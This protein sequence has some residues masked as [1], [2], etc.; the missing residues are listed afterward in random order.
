MRCL[1]LA[2]TA[3]S[4]SFEDT[5]AK[6]R[7]VTRVITLLNDMQK[8]LEKEQETDEE[9]FEQMQ[10]WC[11]T[12]DKDKTAAIKEAEQTIEQLSARIEELTAQSARLHTEIGNLNEEVAENQEALAKATAIREKE[13]AAFTQEEKDMLEAIKSLKSAITVLSKHHESS[14][15]QES[16][17]IHLAADLHRQMSKFPDEFALN[18][19]PADR[20][21]L[22][23]FLQAPGYK[24]YNS[25][26]GQIFGILKNMEE[27]F[28]SNLSDTQKEEQGRQSLFEELKASKEDQIEAGQAQVNKKTEQ[29]A[30]ADNNNSEAKQQRD[31]TRNSL[32][33]DEQ[34]LMNLKEKCAM[35]DKEWEQRQKA[36]QE[37]I[38][39]VGKAISI[40]SADDSHDTFTKTFESSFV[41][42]SS[43]RAAAASVL[44][45]AAKKFHNPR[46]A[47]LASHV[48]LDAFT[49]VKAAIDQLMV[50]LQKQKEDEIKHK[51]W[52]IVALNENDRITGNR[53]R[54]KMDTQAIIESQK[55][56]IENLS[57]RIKLLYSEVAEIRVQ[58]K[59]AGEDREKQNAEFQETVKDQRESQGLLLKAINVLKAVY[60]KKSFLQEEPAGPPP[61][62]GFGAYKKNAQSGGVISMI[63]QIIE[64]AKAMEAEAIKD[65]SDAQKAYEEYVQESNQSVQTKMKARVNDEEAK[66]LTEQALVESGQELEGLNVELSQLSNEKQDVNKSCDFVLKNFDVRQRARDEEV[67]ALRQAKAI[68]SG[69]KFGFLQKAWT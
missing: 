13:Y 1:F 3:S 60:K 38:V 2:L 46:L 21:M 12:N 43:D 34:F 36:R 28:E 24:S 35:T 69:S 19:L 64:D 42:V 16:D 17:F 63:E 37:E 32:S 7:P 18:L 20:R 8:Q 25:Q 58:L 65:E 52:C 23:Q 29:K 9:V 56:K 45:Q 4:I 47:N 10:C 40:L 15:L 57:E 26:S 33:A 22:N 6:N 68:L 5:Y 66:A 50:E 27:T 30:E 67:D 51:D 49:K 59:R 14:M 55:S 48:R 62:A 44:S 54:D 39:A 31:D 53:S 41:Q 11:K 61:P